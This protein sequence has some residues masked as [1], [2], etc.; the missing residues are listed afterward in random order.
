M[1]TVCFYFHTIFLST[2]GGGGGGHL[3]SGHLIV[4]KVT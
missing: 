3:Q 1:D 4:V 2:G